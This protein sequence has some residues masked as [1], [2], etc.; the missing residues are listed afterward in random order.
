MLVEVF[1]AD[2]VILLAGSRARVTQGA[3]PAGSRQFAGD[4]PAHVCHE[5]VPDSWFWL[6]AASF[7]QRTPAAGVYGAPSLETREM[8]VLPFG[9]AVLD[10]LAGSRTCCTHG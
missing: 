7:T 4:H 6:L 3:F 10:T 5:R 1:G 2:N 8:V 9:S